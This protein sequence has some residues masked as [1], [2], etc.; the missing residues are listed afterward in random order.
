VQ[1]ASAHEYSAPRL[2][3]VHFADCKT[4]AESR[5]CSNRMWV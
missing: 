5:Y 3:A 1:N 2:C 4:C